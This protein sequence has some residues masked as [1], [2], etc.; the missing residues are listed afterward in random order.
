MFGCGCG[1]GCAIWLSGC[2]VP[3]RP[4]RP[5]AWSETAAAFGAGGAAAIVG[6]RARRSTL[7]SSRF[8]SRYA[9]RPHN[10]A[11]TSAARV[12]FI[13]AVGGSS[14]RLRRRSPTAFAAPHLTQLATTPDFALLGIREGGGV[15]PG[16]AVNSPSKEGEGST[17]GPPHASHGATHAPERTSV[18]SDRGEECVQDTRACVFF[19][20]F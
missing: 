2:L 3:S 14:N 5:L 1:C 10:I 20:F 9:A 8:A 15:D 6:A 11:W 13:A 7:S 18:G 17:T 19:F 16:F 4:R 12:A